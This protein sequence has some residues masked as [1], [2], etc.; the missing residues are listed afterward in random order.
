AEIAAA[1]QKPHWAY[2]A[3]MSRFSCCFCIMSNQSDLTTAARL[4]PVL[5]RKYVE[6]ER[7]TGQ[8]MMM[9]SKTHGKR[10][11]EQITGIA[12]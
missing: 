5:Y 10:T 6:L 1:G 11:L 9:P 4:N 2:A 12:A 7:S 8:V 3:G